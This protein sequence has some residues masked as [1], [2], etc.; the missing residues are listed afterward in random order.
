MIFRDYTT[1]P[2]EQRNVLPRVKIPSAL[3]IALNKLQHHLVSTVS[4]NC[5]NYIKCI[6]SLSNVQSIGHDDYFIVFK[7]CLF[8]EQYQL[9]LDMT[10]YHLKSHKIQKVISGYYFIINVPSMDGEKSVVRDDI[11]I[12]HEVITKKKFRGRVVNVE[13]NNVTVELQYP[14]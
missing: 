11:V 7:I 8:L 13:E 3:Y 6:E 12:L 2:V 5:D 9:D 4:Q 14:L 1:H 10:R